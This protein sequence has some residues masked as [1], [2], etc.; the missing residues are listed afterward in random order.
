MK[1]IDGCLA[2]YSRTTLAVSSVEPSFTTMISVENSLSYI[3]ERIWSRVRGIRFSSLCAVMTML[4][5]NIMA[6][7]R[8]LLLNLCCS[9]SGPSFSGL[10]YQALVVGKT[11]LG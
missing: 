9:H 8:C 10:I 11:G 2:A 1:T 3:Q 5:V 7:V 4:K 6:C